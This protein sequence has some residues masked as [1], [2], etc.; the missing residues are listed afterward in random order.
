MGQPLY[1]PVRRVPQGCD[2][3]I[4]PSSPKPKCPEPGKNLWQRADGGGMILCDP[5]D[6]EAERFV[7]SGEAVPARRG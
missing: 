2:Y 1:R 4:T 6:A 5:H 3:G 7:A